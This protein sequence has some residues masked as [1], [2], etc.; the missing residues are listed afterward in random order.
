MD[1]DNINDID[2][3]STKEKDNKKENKNL[4]NLKN[5]NNEYKNIDQLKKNILLNKHLEKEI[6]YFIY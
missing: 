5:Y 6:S 4:Q 2:N 3:Y 1:N